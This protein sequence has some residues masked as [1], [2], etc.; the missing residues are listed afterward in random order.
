MCRLGRENICE[1][2]VMFG[3]NVDG[4]YAEFI[5]APAKDIFRLPVEIPLV[6]GSI[7]A[8]AISTPY[9]AVKNRAQV[10]AGDKVVV[11]GCGG[12][13]INV[14]QVAAAAGGVV[15]AV[16]ISEQK[17]EVAK[18]L[19]AWQTVN[20]KATDARKA[21]K[22]LFDGGA[23]IA[24]EAIGNPRTIEQSVECLRPGGRL[25]VVGY[26]DQPAQLNAAR[27]M[28][29]ELDI[30]GS[31]GCRPVDYPAIID[32]VARKAIQLQPVITR[33]FPLDEIND[34]LDFL[35]NGN[36]FRTVVKVAEL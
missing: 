34:A 19:G 31:L 23:D 1:R 36:G 10:R 5:A 27:L 29:R 15:V 30:V 7:I 24:L 32:M 11:F 13:G 2:M 4:G 26:T 20:P 8:D 3:N 6:D 33:R 28:Y 35:R 9:H 18:Q 16:D 22:K 17:L 21:V 25:C 12:V 14:V